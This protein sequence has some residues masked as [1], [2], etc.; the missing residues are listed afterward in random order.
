MAVP[1]NAADTA[2]DPGVDQ[3]HF[4]DFA[5]S[6]VR[7]NRQDLARGLVSKRQRQL[8]AAV[9]QGK[10]PTATQIK[11]AVPNMQ[12]GMTNAC[13]LDG[14][15][16]LI[17]GRFRIGQVHFPQRATEID[18]LI[19]LHLD[20][21]PRHCRTVGTHICVKLYREIPR[22]YRRHPQLFNGKRSAPG[23]IVILL[24]GVA[25]GY[26]AGGNGCAST[27]QKNRLP[28]SCGSSRAGTPPPR[29]RSSTTIQSAPPGASMGRI[30]T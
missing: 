4:T 26:L 20:L 13:G 7:T 15:H 11:T 3:A 30:I 19:T 17:S 18:D 10:P 28:G 9:L 27:V 21:P 22:A 5:L 29:P 1:A 8:D 2:A 6:H 12:V 16:D 25:A 14:E 24:V 23:M